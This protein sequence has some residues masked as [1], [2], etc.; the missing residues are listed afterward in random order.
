MRLI[1]FASFMLAAHGL[2]P[3]SGAAD[4]TVLAALALAAIG[5]GRMIG[6]RG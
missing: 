2:L 5:A 4:L 6:A 1:L 3:D